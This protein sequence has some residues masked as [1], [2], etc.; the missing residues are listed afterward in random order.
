MTKTTA[1]SP[2]VG[3]IVTYRTIG[4]EY[5]RVEIEIIGDE[6][7]NGRPVFDAILLDATNDGSLPGDLVWGYVADIVR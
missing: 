4:G 7:K 5:R 3:D 6:T 1:N 2:K